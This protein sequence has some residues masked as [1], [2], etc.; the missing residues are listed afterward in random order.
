MKH[1]YALYY[2]YKEK[3][4]TQAFVDLFVWLHMQKTREAATQ[5]E[6]QSVS[7]SQNNRCYINILQ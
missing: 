7:I 1:G 6:R 5:E 2:S 4:S 3:T